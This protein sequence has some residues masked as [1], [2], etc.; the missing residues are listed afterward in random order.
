M[1]KIA[2]FLIQLLLLLF[3]LTWI[4][5]NPFII[6]LD[7]GNF[8]YSFSSNILSGFLVVLFFAIYLLTY[9]YFKS[10]FS[11][12]N[13]ILK[14]KFKK[15]EKG[16]YYFVE[17]MIAIANK[18]H[19]TAINS[20]KKMSTYLKDNQTLS[21]LLKS[22]VFK[23]E[24]KSSALI[25]VYEAM[26]KSKK[27]ESLG[28]RG[29][30]EINLNNQDYHHAFLYGEKLFSLNPKI[31]KLYDTL[32]YIAARTKNWNQLIL[33][34]DKA[35]SKK[36]I[37][38]E[39]LNE[40]KSIG[41]YEI[42][43][44]KEDS[45]INESINYILKAINLKRNFNP[46]I[47]LH[48]DLLSKSNNKK[49][50]LKNIKKYWTQNPNSNL[51]DIITSF[52]NDYKLDS[53]NI[54]NDIIRSSYDHGESKKLLIYFAIFNKNWKLARDNIQGLIGPNPSREVCL[55]MADI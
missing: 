49:L 44:I 13:F 20:H 54:I 28:Y 41:F 33:I 10:R 18:D 25:N 19:K 12:Q 43:K 5:T 42:A 46:Y 7:I 47:K 17:A 55:F 3:I 39:A 51:R 11:I 32:I 36:I 38:K 53:L 40:N 45:N 37:S 16:Y 22:E 24:K 1:Y 50:L 9:I 23:I 14:N 2:V 6:S 4:F 34:S 30:M 29:L 15:I 8:K 31:D 48:L 21:L 26:I 52:L 35:Y 27:T